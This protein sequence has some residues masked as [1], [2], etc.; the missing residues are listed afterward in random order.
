MI[1]LQ[2][3]ARIAWQLTLALYVTLLL[4]LVLDHT[5]LRPQFYLP[6]LLIQT[7]PLLLVFPGLLKQQAR[8]GIWL[9]FMILFHFLAAVGHAGTAAHNSFYIVMT[10]I[11]LT[12]FTTSLLFVRWQKAL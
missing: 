4:F 3:K 7:L 1:T 5:W 12:L 8:S 9:C 10:I 6:V 2:N 11:I